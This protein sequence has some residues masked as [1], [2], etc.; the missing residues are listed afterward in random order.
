MIE[1]A[2]LTSKKLQQL[3]TISFIIMIVVIGGIW[4]I[5][6]R[7]TLER[8]AERMYSKQVSMIAVATKPALMFSDK[9]LARALITQFKNNRADVTKLQLLTVNGVILAS[10]PQLK[11]EAG[12]K[13]SKGPTLKAS[14]YKDGQLGLS[15]TV[16]HKG[17]PVGMVYVEFSLSELKAHTQADIINI[18]V[19]MMSV[20][21]LSWWVINQ[22]QR[23]LIDSEDKL[24]QAVQQAELANRAKTDFLSTISHELRTPIHGIIG[25]QK[26]I[27]EDAGQLSSEQRENLLLAQQSAKS[28]RA[29]VNDVLDL[30]KIE[31]GKMQLTKNKFDLQQCV[32]EALVPFRVLAIEKGIT[33]SLHIDNSPKEILSDESRLRQILLNLVGNAVKFTHEGEVSVHVTKEN[34]QLYFVV[35]D[36]G[37]GIS[38][39]DLKHIFEAFVQGSE[40]HQP[41]YFGSGLGTSIVKRFVELMG[42]TIQVESTLGEGSSFAFNIPCY[43]SGSK[44]IDYHMNSDTHLSEHPSLPSNESIAT[45]PP[46]NL[47]VLLAEDDL[48]S[49]RIVTKRFSKAG[50]HV[51][52]VDNGEDA[53]KKLQSHSYNLL[54][55]DVRMPKLDGLELTKKIRSMEKDLNRPRLTIVGLSAHALEEVVQECLDAGMDYF[56]SKPVDPQEILATVVMHRNKGGK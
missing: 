11:V 28:L 6:D 41:Q 38:D 49:Q 39:E 4:I 14:S 52:V 26:L 8:Q 17:L 43:P 35:K 30:A 10:F 54:L 18:L 44:V 5:Y 40:N 29:L 27:S 45:E 3:I 53:F 22:L 21:L 56:M 13:Y 31:S 15:R 7:I 55:T 23:K 1:S 33:L 46:L 50:I 19:I 37:I 34:D 36:S 9:K 12:S 32:C 51:D 25:L 48:I 47:R 2:K 24:H 20:L 16:L 42:G